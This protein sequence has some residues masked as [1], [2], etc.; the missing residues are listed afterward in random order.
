MSGVTSTWLR[1]ACLLLAVVAFVS[2]GSVQ[3][4]GKLEAAETCRCVPDQWEGRLF[5]TDREYD[6]KSGQSG[7]AE[8]RLFIHYDYTNKRFA[9]VDTLTGNKAIA[10]YGKGIKYVVRSNGCHGMATDEPMR[11]MCLP[12]EA[13]L[14]GE[15]SI[16][17]NVPIT[18]WQFDGPY[19][20]S[21]KTTVVQSNCLPLTEEV[22]MTRGHFTSVSSSMYLDVTPGIKDE[23]DFMAP[24]DCLVETHRTSPSGYN[25]EKSSHVKRKAD[26][27]HLLQAIRNR[28]YI[29][30]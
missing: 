1:V 16:G 3:G 7:V 24:A 9:M 26:P 25:H 15:H 29:F 20:V 4:L 11:R 22:S 14:M 8:T 28:L 21:M 13:V 17:D 19:N 2:T 30:H 10:D 23:S 27:N 5:S 18:M 12:D 6:L